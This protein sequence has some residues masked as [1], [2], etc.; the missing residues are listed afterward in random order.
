[1]NILCL[2]YGTKRIGV[3]VAI[4]PLAEPLGI[5]PNSKNPKLSDIVT[6]QALAHIE[7]LV[8]EYA[9]EKIV[10]GISEGEMAEKSRSFIERLKRK[11]NLPI[12]EVDETLSSVRAGEGMRHMK[13]AK[14]EGNRD[15]LAA[16]IML[17]E[18]LDMHE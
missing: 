14:R 13:K 9:I 1:M 3:A 16:A 6:D 11:V 7:K 10:V 8:T 2:D 12:D 5:I 18:Y 17:Q 15:H 4:S